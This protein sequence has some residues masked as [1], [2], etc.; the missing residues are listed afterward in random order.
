MSDLQDQALTSE[1]PRASADK[2]SGQ[3]TVEKVQI[4]LGTPTKTVIIEAGEGGRKR[5]VKK[6]VRIVKRIVRK[7]VAKSV[8][9]S[10]A[11]NEESEKGIRIE[12]SGS[13]EPCR[14]VSTSS[15]E[16]SKAGDGNVKPYVGDENLKK[17]EPQPM[18]V[19]K[20]SIFAD[21][22]PESGKMHESE[23]TIAEKPLQVVKENSNCV[24]NQN[25]G[26]EG[27]RQD[28][29]G[30]SVNENAKSVED[31][32]L[33]LVGEAGTEESPEVL[34]RDVEWSDKVTLN[35]EARTKGALE[36]VKEVLESDIEGSDK[37]TLSE[38]MEA[39][40]RKRRRRTQIFIG[41]LDKD[42]KEE[43]I[44]QV[45]EDVGE[46]MELRLLINRETGKN[47]GFA[48]L[49]FASAA[50]AK[51][52]VSNYSQVEVMDMILQIALL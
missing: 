25:V 32:G 33:G 34:E 7:K 36:E 47:K 9:K 41:G 1:L 18:E 14:E 5:V 35:E 44:R 19:E 26:K 2:N 16:N 42:T 37:V 40:E 49:R 17:S 6:T 4:E 38:E 12:E 52:A 50:D 15:I 45:F 8:P 10:C 23:L 43:D 3:A 39:L 20:G 21:A 27:V 48:F 11:G 51:K 28:D 24:E 13:F 22:V 46:V 31:W 30:V 29:S